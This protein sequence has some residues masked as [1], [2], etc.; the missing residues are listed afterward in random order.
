MQ[1]FMQRVNQAI[2]DLKQ[3][4][5]VILT[6]HPD[7]ENEGDLIIPA[8]K[9]TPEIMNFMI[10][11]GT[12]IVCL[13][14]L[15]EKMQAL[16]L[17]LMVPPDNND[18]PTG[19]PFTISIDAKD[20]ITTGV[21]AKDRALTVLAAIEDNATPQDLAR[22]GHIFP[23]QARVGG[24]LEREGHTEGSIDLSVL[25]GFKPA[26]V[27][28]EIMNPDGTMTYGKQLDEFAEKHN[29]TMLSI[30]DIIH[31]RL[32]TENL[33]ADVAATQLPTEKF[34]TL[35]CT[36]IKE[37]YTK[38]E[39][40]VLVND[41][42]QSTL[43]LLV[44]IHSSCSTGDLFCSKR[45]DCN[46]QLQHALQ[47]IHVE[48]G[49][50]IYLNQEGRGIGLLNK[51]KAYALQEQGMDTVE[52]NEQLGL[53]VDARKYYIAANILRNL[54]VKHIR[55]LTNNLHKIED[56]KKYGIEQVERAA[57]P[58]FHNEHNQHYLQTKQE[59]LAHVINFD[60]IANLGD[61]AS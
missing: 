36:V 40:L 47:R 33:I 26:A 58:S 54:N 45:C 44:R 59:K 56:L 20:N 28:C 48:G 41:K 30:D 50:L 23:L 46:K 13:S 1:A 3:G 8:E 49:M 24:V 18:S 25:A 6:D 12:G 42:V 53:P 29:L 37:K 57:L 52:A 22:P 27:I 31:Y 17:P 4:K 14:M 55:L 60:N 61:L 15:P 35:T 51:I 5:A 43:P 19:T 7:R 39:H 32:S 16:N 2:A 38:L 10:R 34:G 11:N 9:I 21:S